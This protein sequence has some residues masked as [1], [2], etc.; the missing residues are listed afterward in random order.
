MFGIGKNNENII[1]CTGENHNIFALRNP[2]DKDKAGIYTLWV[3]GIHR[4]KKEYDIY[5]QVSENPQSPHWVKI[6][7]EKPKTKLEEIKEFLK[8]FPT[9]QVN[10]SSLLQLT[11]II[12][13]LAEEV[14]KE[15]K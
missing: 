12:Q 15:N 2:T 6:Y 1:A 7:W 9:M 5:L 14:F 3:N 4:I 8:E 10:H 11:G 13:E